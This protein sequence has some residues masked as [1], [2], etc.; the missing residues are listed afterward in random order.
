VRSLTLE[1]GE[2]E[3]G[4]EDPLDAQRLGLWYPTH[5][6]HKADSAPGAVQHR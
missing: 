3:D 2:V 6:H 4:F 5:D 1:L